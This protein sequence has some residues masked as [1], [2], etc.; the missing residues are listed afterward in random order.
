[1]VVATTN[2][3]AQTRLGACNVRIAQLGGRT[4]ERRVVQVCD[5]SPWAGLFMSNRS[6]AQNVYY[7]GLALTLGSEVV[8]S[9]I[10]RCQR[11]VVCVHLSRR[12]RVLVKQRRLRQQTEMYEHSRRY[13]MRRLP[14]WMD[15]RWS[16]ELYRC[17]SG[18]HF[19]ISILISK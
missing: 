17:V 13:E 15:Q 2:A 6:R 14:F 18:N 1:M 10:E 7:C 16:E 11:V 12:E 9:H 5:W 3:N 19:A 8:V 4:M